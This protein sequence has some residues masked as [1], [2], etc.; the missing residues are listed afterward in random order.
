MHSTIDDI[1]SDMA[2]SISLDVISIVLGRPVIRSRPL[3]LIVSSSGLGNAQP[4]FILISSAVLSPM[5]RLYS[6]LIYPMI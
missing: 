1:G 6:L 4:I 5:A 2:E 3:M